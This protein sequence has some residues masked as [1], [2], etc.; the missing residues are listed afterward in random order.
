MTQETGTSGEV[1]EGGCGR[2]PES[3]Q[4]VLC[5]KLLLVKWAKYRR[6]PVR[7]RSGCHY[8]AE[9]PS[10]GKESPQ[11]RDPG[12]SSGVD[13]RRHRES[14]QEIELQGGTEAKRRSAQL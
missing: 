2:A 6:I 8:G 11:G 1:H 10:A 7:F 14:G 5:Q 12:V 13:S 9:H 3:P 4:R